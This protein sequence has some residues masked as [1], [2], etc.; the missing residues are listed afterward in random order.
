MKIPKLLY[1]LYD[2][3]IN[4]VVYITK[5]KSDV[6]EF[7]KYR[8]EEK[9]QIATV[10]DETHIKYLL[11][12]DLEGEKINDFILTK[13]EFEYFSDYIGSLNSTLMYDLE[14]KILENLKYLKLCD[15]DIEIITKGI[16][17]LKNKVSQIYEG[18]TE[19]EEII[20]EESVYDLDKLLQKFF[21]DTL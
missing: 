11:N 19:D 6:K 4:E 15:E 20:D 12:N 13:Y 3:E 21:I 10:T 17:I 18:P 1:V 7:L 5:D 9:F 8:D 16:N 2:D 14:I